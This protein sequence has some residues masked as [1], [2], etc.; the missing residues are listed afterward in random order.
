MNKR[1]RVIAALHHEE[2]DFIPYNVDLT[3][4]THDLLA[5]A[6]GDPAFEDKI[7]N[8]LAVIGYHGNHAPIP[9]RPGF[10]RD[11]FG[12][13]WD[14]RETAGGLGAIDEIVL[15]EPTLK[16]YQMPE[17]DEAWFRNLFQELH[18]LPNAPD[19]FKMIMVGFS[20]F[21]R[22]WA[23]RGMQNLLEDML[24]NESFV[25]ELLGQLC[26]RNLKIVDIALSCGIDGIFFGDDWG[27]QSGMIMGPECWRRIFKPH[28]ARL[29]ARVKSAG[30]FVL[31]HSCGDIGEILGDLIDI[32]LDAYQTVMPEIYN[33]SEIKRKFGK[34]LSF[35]GAISA[36][37]L[38]PHGTP[39]EVR[40]GVADT[41]R[42]MG[43]GGGYIAGPTH[44][45][46]HDVPVENIL[47]LID[48]LQNQKAGV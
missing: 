5:K 35:W 30:K 13:V 1:D 14:C 31:Q 16:G 7:G 8:H 24:M 32:G 46:T 38:L 23:M 44:T 2:T 33:L 28:I 48:V 4:Q 37:G 27:Q 42:I 11:D 22:A 6:L 20:M 34:N 17:V 9:G 15:K 45:I 25:D 10:F 43:P 26:E 19:S 47:A 21:E 3:S 18:R 39:Q 41:L 40:K 12:V 29:Y 36:Q